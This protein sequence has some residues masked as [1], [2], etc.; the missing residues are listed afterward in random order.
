M[1]SNI[2]CVLRLRKTYFEC[3]NFDAKI[4][5]CAIVGTAFEMTGQAP[6]SFEGDEEIER[7]CLAQ[8][9]LVFLSLSILPYIMDLTREVTEY[10]TKNIPE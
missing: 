8:R 9:T 1:T 7:R 3:Q 6:G 10:T 2:I 4:Q 5:R